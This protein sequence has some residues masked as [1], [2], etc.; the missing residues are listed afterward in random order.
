MCRLESGL[1]IVISRSGMQRQKKREDRAQNNLT[2]SNLE[3]K[4]RDGTRGGTRR[5]ALFMETKVKKKRR[6]KRFKQKQLSQQWGKGKGRLR[7]MDFMNK[8]Y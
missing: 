5:T 3:K 1:T 7:K 4:N 2:F 8:G 6:K